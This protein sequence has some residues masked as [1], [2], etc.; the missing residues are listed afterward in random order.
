MPKTTTLSDKFSRRGVWWLPSNPVRKISGLVSFDPTG[1]LDIELDGTLREEIP[2]GT[3]QHFNAPIIYGETLDGKACTLVDAHESSFQT[4]SPGGATSKLFFNQLVI[5]PQHIDPANTTY[6]S[7]I[8]DISDFCGWM[9]R[10]PFAHDNAASTDGKQTITYSMPSIIEI[11]V[12][13]L[14]ATISI[15]SALN[16]VM[17]YQQRTLTHR[18]SIRIKPT[19][20]QRLDWYIKAIFRLRVLWSLLIGRPVIILAAR[21]CTSAKIFPE[22]GGK[23]H[24]EYVDICFKQQGTAPEK[25]LLPPE[26]PFTY[27]QLAQD[28]PAILNIWFAKAA[29]LA[30]LSGLFFG[31]TVNRGMPVEFEFLSL[32][33]ALESYHRTQGMNKYVAATVYEGIKSALTSAIPNNTPTDLRDA[34]SGRIKYGNEYSLRKRLDLTLE[35]V[36][37][38]LTNEIT[39]GNSSFVAQVVSTRNYLTHRDETQ[40]DNV[41]DFRGMINA[42]V[43]L[44]ILVQFL[45]LMEIGIKPNTIADVMCKHWRYKNRPRIL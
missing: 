15:E 31:T 23:R 35:L 2:K 32:I 1:E 21:L 42:S 22:H 33:Q 19:Q 17:E 44:R 34:L 30:T 11:N 25:E 36:P 27:P 6:E 40:K 24:R 4:H 14:S 20:Q 45:L 43:S 10:D 26:I 41:L 38:E 5:G 39:L 18:D 9:H 16:T 28:F 13:D 29:D 12:P 7:A 37:T 3:Y 8:I